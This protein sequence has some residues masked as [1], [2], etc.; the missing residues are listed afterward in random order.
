MPR[1]RAFQGILG[2]GAPKALRQQ[3][4]NMQDTDGAV[5]GLGPDLLASMTTGS[6]TAGQYNIHRS[7]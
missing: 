7:R 5:V 6:M 1:A 2:E 4:H 3:G